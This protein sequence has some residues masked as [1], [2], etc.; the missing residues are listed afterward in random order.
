MM[1]IKQEM[2]SKCKLSILRCGVYKPLDTTV[3][4]FIYKW[5][6]MQS[7]VMGGTG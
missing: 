4:A 7:I 3:Y 6:G 2:I 5:E 1:S